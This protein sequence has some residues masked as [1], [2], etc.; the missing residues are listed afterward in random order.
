MYAQSMLSDMCFAHNVVLTITSI[1]SADYANILMLMLSKF[2]AALGRNSS[3]S[4]LAAAFDTASYLVCRALLSYQ[5]FTRRDE[6][7]V[8]SV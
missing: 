1:K 2:T 4:E 7:T 3:A 5:T 6:N 8:W